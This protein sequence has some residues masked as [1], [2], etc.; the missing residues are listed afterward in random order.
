MLVF[1]KNLTVANGHGT[2]TLDIKAPA[3]NYRALYP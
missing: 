3:T 1:V 2:V